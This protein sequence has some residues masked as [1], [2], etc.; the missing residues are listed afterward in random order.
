MSSDRL[1]RAH[2]APA[3]A[4]TRD[5]RFAAK[6]R[7]DGQPR[8]SPAAAG[9]SGQRV[10][11]DPR[12]IPQPAGVLLSFADEHVPDTND[13]PAMRGKHDRG[14]AIGAIAFVA[15]RSCGAGGSVRLPRGHSDR[16]LG[17]VGLEK[18]VV[19][20]ACFAR[21]AAIAIRGMKLLVEVRPAP[22]VGSADPGQGP[23]WENADG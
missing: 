3:A 6:R 12:S 22:S 14:T 4:R 8:A 16:E 23:L 17:D 7:S 10:G 11:C 19:G 20:P 21:S 15:R 1:N 13:A 2:L 18:A 5:Y 9:L